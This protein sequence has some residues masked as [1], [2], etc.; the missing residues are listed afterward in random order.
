MTGNNAPRDAQ[1]YLSQLERLK[2]QAAIW[3]QGV[4]TVGNAGALRDLIGEIDAWSKAAEKDRK[5]IKEPYIEQGRRIDAQFKPVGERAESFMKPLKAMLTSFLQAEEKRKREEAD[6]ARK[7]ADEKARLAAALAD[8]DVFGARVADM[9]KDAQQAA[10]Q[11]QRLAQYN[12]VKGDDADRAL[13]LRTYRKAKIV[14][15]AMI[16]AHFAD[17]PEVI[18]VCEKLANAAIRAASGGPV[19]IPGIEIIEEKRVA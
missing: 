4:V 16:V 13:G 1:F 19:A 8:D 11:A 5:A 14:N 6:A 3:A 10:D 17:H 12:A 15:A 18:A 9:A 7:E 2:A